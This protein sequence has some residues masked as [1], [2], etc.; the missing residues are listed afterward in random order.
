MAAS[1]W[2]AFWIVLALGFGMGLST[3]Q[4]RAQSGRHGDGHAELHS[5]YEQWKDQRGYS[6]CDD[7]DCR[8][9]RAD[10]GDDGRWRAWIDGRWIPVPA[11]AVL[12][13]RSPD[14]RSHVCMSPGAQ[15]PRCFVPGEPRS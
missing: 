5:T 10:K 15:E 4:A 9:T 2:I 6:C 1:S 12:D 11:D 13:R 3:H 14:G 7:G 8:P